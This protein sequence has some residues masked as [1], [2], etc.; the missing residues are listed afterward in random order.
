ME[1]VNDFPRR[2]GLL[3]TERR[4]I[5]QSLQLKAIRTVTVGAT[6]KKTDSLI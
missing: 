4:D 2:N 6:R 5:H 1:K 3:L